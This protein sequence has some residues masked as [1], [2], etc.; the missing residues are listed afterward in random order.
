MKSQRITCICAYLIAFDGLMRSSELLNIRVYD[1]VF[2]KIY[3]IIIESTK[4]DKYR[5]G[6]WIT[7]AR[8]GTCLCPVENTEKLI[9]WAS[10]KQSDYF[11]LQ[12]V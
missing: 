12:S 11:V 8:T 1:I 4:T 9:S 7:I 2:N 10:L 6:T 3:M 5:D